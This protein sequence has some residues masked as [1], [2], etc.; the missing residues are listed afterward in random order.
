MRNL[1]SHLKLLAVSATNFEQRLDRIQ[2][3]LGRI[4]SRHVRALSTPSFRDAEFRVYSQWGEDGIIQLLLKYV[5]IE[6]HT[7]VEFG[8]ENYRESNT[9]FLLMHDN[10]SGLVIDGSERN[11]DFIR[12]DAIFWRHNLKADCAFVSREN[13]NELLRRNGLEGDL[14]LLSIDID[15]N[16]YWVWETIDVVKPR[17]VIAE[18][19]SRFGADR[20]VTV[21][22]RADFTRKEAHPSMIYYGASLAALVHLGNRK[23]YDFVG[24]NSAGNNAFFVRRDVRPESLPVLTAQAG[25]VRS[26]FRE[27]RDSA[28]RLM[29]STFEEE[30]ALLN[31]LPLTEVP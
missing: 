27:T 18:Y 29:F 11:I 9:R 26:Q 15:G 1:I 20:S 3:T 6:R 24:S 13:I 7:F 21:P 31:T 17:I 12:N 10:W 5:P 25:Y 2:E 28:G 30:Q 23:G 16:D 4:E 8:V 19:N 22:Y 14:G